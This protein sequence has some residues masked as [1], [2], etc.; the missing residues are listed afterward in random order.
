MVKGRKITLKERIEI[1]SDCISNNRDYGKTIDTYGVS[2]QQIY[3][4]VRKY[5]KAGADEFVD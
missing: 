5:E 4:W 3:A 1:V 2:Y